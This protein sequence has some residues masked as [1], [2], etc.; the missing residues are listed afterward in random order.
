MCVTVNVVNCIIKLLFLVHMLCQLTLCHDFVGIVEWLRQPAC[1]R[2]LEIRH[3]KLV[4]YTRAVNSFLRHLVSTDD[5]V[6]N[7]CIKA[8]YLLGM[9][10]ETTRISLFLG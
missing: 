9:E 2:R 1:R 10:M 7:T 6:I 4:N 5:A 3:V 8:R